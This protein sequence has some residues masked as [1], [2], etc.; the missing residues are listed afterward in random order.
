MVFSKW[1]H[2]LY[3]SFF[4]F[5][6]LLK[7]TSKNAQNT[8]GLSRSRY[9]SQELELPHFHQPS[10]FPFQATPFSFLLISLVWLVVLE[11]FINGIYSKYSVSGLSAQFLLM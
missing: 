9:L 6:T 4:F 8:S 3:A 7:Y 11:L 1:L 2:N 5:K 10:S